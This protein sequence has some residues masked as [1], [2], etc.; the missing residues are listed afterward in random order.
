MVCNIKYNLIFVYRFLSLNLTQDAKIPSY[1]SAQTLGYAH[2]LCN[3][4]VTV[5]HELEVS[6]CYR[7]SR[8]R[9]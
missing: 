7:T 5:Q 6:R 2:A 4:N 3:V 9:S 1:I 8:N